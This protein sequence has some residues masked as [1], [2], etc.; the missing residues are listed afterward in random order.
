MRYWEN[1][2]FEALPL[3][4][5][6]FPVSLGANCISQGVEDR[7]SLISVP[8]GPLGK[9]PSYVGILYVLF[10]RPPVMMCQVAG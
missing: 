2:H 1:G 10:L 4:V 6:I 9:G 3:R 7:G 8:V 5:A